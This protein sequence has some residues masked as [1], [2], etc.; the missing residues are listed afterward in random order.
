[1]EPGLLQKIEDRVFSKHKLLRT[2]KYTLGCNS[3]NFHLLWS[4]NLFQEDCM[5]SIITTDCFQYHYLTENKNRLYKTRVELPIFSRNNANPSL[6]ESV[7][8]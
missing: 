6:L 3:A 4:K 1:M 2:Q 5:L 7:S 8:S